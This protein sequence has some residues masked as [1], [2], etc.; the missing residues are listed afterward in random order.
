M[1]D[2]PHTDEYIQIRGLRLHYVDYGGKGET[3]IAL[4]GL[5]QNARSYD[6][7]APLLVPHV[8][9]IAISLRGR[10]E[11]QW[12][13]E[14]QY[15]IQEYLL[16]FKEF[17]NQL[18]LQRMALLGTSL[19]GVLARMFA[20][21]LPDRVSRLVLNDTAIGGNPSGFYR[22]ATRPGRA[23]EIFPDLEAAVTWFMSERPGLD[24][25]DPAVMHHFVNQ[26]LT[27]AETG[28]LRFHCD[29]AVIRMSNRLAEQLM[30]WKRTSN[31]MELA[32]EQ[33]KRLT[34]P[35]LLIRGAVSDVLPPEIA[36]RLTQ[37]LPHARFVDIPGVSHSPT[38]YEP[39]SQEALA[40]FFGVPKPNLAAVSHL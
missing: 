11:S 21:V 22:I 19:G 36:D 23:P 6:A 16:D 14:D 29:P 4:P 10:G 27:P 31:E 32:W 40:D 38:L 35:V 34:M 3:L 2:F 1:L 37:T 28:G 33:V 9:L 39:E 5:I 17:L 24:R 30:S 18:G 25:L 8:H 12:G 15:R 13:P 26:Y 20:T 7:I